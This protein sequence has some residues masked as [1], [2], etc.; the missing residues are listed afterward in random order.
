M[1]IFRDD[2]LCESDL[3]VIVYSYEINHL[4]RVYLTLASTIGLR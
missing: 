1:P 3:L 2:S 4:V